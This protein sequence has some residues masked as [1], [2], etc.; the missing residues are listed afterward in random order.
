MSTSTKRP[1]EI[2]TPPETPADCDPEQER[3]T[4]ADGVLRA[5]V[6][7]VLVEQRHVLVRGQALSEALLDVVLPCRAPRARVVGGQTFDQP[8]VQ[9]VSAKGPPT[10]TSMRT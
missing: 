8:P 2:S 5:V 10:T 1:L 7:H 9:V 6:V 3:R 4:L